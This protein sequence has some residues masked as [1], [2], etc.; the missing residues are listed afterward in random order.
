MV[1]CGEVTREY[2]GELMEDE[3]YF[4]EA[5]LSKLISV[6]TLLPQVIKAALLFLIGEREGLS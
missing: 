5:Y 4:S 1:K 3:G 2:V 6:P